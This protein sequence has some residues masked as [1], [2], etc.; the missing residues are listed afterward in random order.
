MNEAF[1][2]AEA[3][4]PH[5]LLWILFGV[6]LLARLAAIHSTIGFY[7]RLALSP[8]RTAASI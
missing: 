8:Q 4:Y 1:T 5:V 6:A 7:T 3:G 2:D